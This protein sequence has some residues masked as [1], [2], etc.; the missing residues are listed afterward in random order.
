[1]LIFFREYEWPWSKLH[2]YRWFWSRPFNLTKLPWAKLPTTGVFRM[3][4]LIFFREYEWPWS[5]LHHYRWFWSRPFNLT[6]L[7]WAKLPTTGVFRMCMFIF[8]REYEPPLWGILHDYNMVGTIL[9][10]CF[11]YSN[12]WNS[13][14]KLSLVIGI[15]LVKYSTQMMEICLK[16]V[17][18]WKFIIF[19]RYWKWTKFHVIWGIKFG[20]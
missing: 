6:K 18:I 4:M 9:Q 1:M 7:P 13:L 14:Y 15:T 8:S 12:L 2:H 16:I 11:K 10:V 3:C 5:K 17:E 20:H 19:R